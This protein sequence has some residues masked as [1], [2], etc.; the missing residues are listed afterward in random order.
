[1]SNDISQI[2]PDDKA[3]DNRVKIISYPKAFVEHQPQN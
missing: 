1:M 3:V 2:K